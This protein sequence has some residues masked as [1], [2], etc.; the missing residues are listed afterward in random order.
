MKPRPSIFCPKDIPPTLPTWS[1]SATIISHWP[2][3]LFS[4]APQSNP[5]E[6]LSQ[7]KWTNPLNIKNQRSNSTRITLNNE[8]ITIKYSI[9]F[10]CQERSSWRICQSLIMTPSIMFLT[11]WKKFNSTFFKERSIRKLLI[12]KKSWNM[13]M[14]FWLHRRSVTVVK[15]WKIT[16]FNSK[17]IPYCSFMILSFG[18]I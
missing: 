4:T 15:L 3:T 6:L 11:T 13:E 16:T 18:E 1:S 9:R 17:K 8:S 5:I 2:K 7:A 14:C 12:S 10:R